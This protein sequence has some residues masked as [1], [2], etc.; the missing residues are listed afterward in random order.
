MT[1]HT[2]QIQTS[3]WHDLIDIT[4]QV[5]AL[6]KETNLEDGM[7]FIFVPHSTAGLTI[8]SYLDPDTAKD[9]NS[10][11]NRLVPTRIDFSHIRD[12]PT[13]AAGHIKTSLIGT[14]LALIVSNG[15]FTFGRSQAILFWEFDG[16]RT[17][18]IQ[19]KFIKG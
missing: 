10:E 7:C 4:P 3:D 9:L 2:I 17:R 14:D 5:R 6:I 19:V 8:N 16:P 11:I 18:T 13:D 12:T 15:D 1:L